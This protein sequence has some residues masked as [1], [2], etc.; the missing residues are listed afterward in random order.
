MPSGARTSARWAAA[1]EENAIA[2]T[3]SATAVEV[4]TLLCRLT[5]PDNGNTP[6]TRDARLRPWRRALG[7]LFAGP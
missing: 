3:T 6:L 1:G 4:D 7:H 2:A 5:A